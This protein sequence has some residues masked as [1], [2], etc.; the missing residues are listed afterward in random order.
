MSETSGPDIAV[1]SDALPAGLAD[2]VAE[3]RWYGAKTTVPRLERIGGWSIDHGDVRIS[4]HYILDRGV[5]RATL[6]QVPLTE[7][8]T[9]LPSLAPIGTAGGRYIYDAPHDPAYALAILGLILTED[10]VGGARGHR[11]P[12]TPP[13]VIS[14][15]AVLRGEQSNTSIICRVENG[16][17]VILKVFRALH[18]GDNPDVVL[19]SAIAAAGSLLVPTS[20]GFLSGQWPDSGRPD[21]IARGHLAFAQEFLPGAE[22]AWRVALLAARTGQDF[23]ERARTLG[24]A[25]AAVHATL[26]EVLPTRLPT[27]ADIDSILAG[28]R[29]RLNLAL[30]EVPAL[31]DC[32]S[33]I[34][35][36]F[37]LARTA[38][39]PPL[40]RIHGDY[41]LGQV[42]DVP[43]RGWV[44]VDFEGEPLRSM[45]E[46]SELDVTLRDVAGMLRS[47]DYAAGSV[48][49]TG[50]GTGPAESVEA[51]APAARHAFIDGYIARSGVNLRLRREVV[52]AFE[53]DKALYEAVY[54]ARNRPDWIAIPVEAVRRLAH[55][56]TP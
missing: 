1:L 46:R 44:I 13:L 17:P 23:A 53:I 21:G 10:E 15:S 35:R 5:D 48:A 33:S 41:H 22:D 50:G 38:P 28:M 30:R 31:E 8:I 43:G 29:A 56:A 25:T 39:W 55:C 42:L 49:Q 37:E 11:Q 32:R 27:A 7:R 47:F 18:N 24:E 9:P 14:D 2:W 45:T 20:V 16:T 6:Y 52:D 12:G 19:Q 54:E 3:Q 4:T 26:S 40:Q 36:L 34:E 51:W